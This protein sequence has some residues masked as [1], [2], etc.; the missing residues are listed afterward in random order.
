MKID[1]N[2][3][4]QVG[5]LIRASRKAMHIRQDDAAGIIGVSENFLGKVQRGGETVQWGKLFQVLHELGL[6]ITVEVPEPFADAI[7]KRLTDTQNKT[8]TDRNKS[9]ASNSDTAGHKVD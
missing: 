7:V 5:A 2:F 1:I 6:N 8:P 4:E 9:A 3:P